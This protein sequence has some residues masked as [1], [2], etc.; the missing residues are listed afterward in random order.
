MP[1]PFIKDR[2][3]SSLLCVLKETLLND[4]YSRLQYATDT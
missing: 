1:S 2:P 3:R 4:P